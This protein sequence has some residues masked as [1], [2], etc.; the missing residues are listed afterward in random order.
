M[1]VKQRKLLGPIALTTTLTTNVYNNASSAIETVIKEI[2]FVNKTAS[3]ATVSLYI[4]AT[5]AN[6][7]GTELYLGFSV[8]A[9]DVFGEFFSNLVLQ[10]TDFIVGGS[11]TATAIGIIIL[12][13]LIAT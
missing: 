5:G 1:P 13:E 3:A 9:N 11:G 8:A 2:R 6:A 12:G 7:A 10:S 4:G